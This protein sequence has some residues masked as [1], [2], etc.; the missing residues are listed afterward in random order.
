L[1]HVSCFMKF[2]RLLLTEIMSGIRMNCLRLLTQDVH[3]CA[4]DVLAL[5]G[6]QSM[7]E[8]GC[9]VLVGVLIP[10]TQGTNE[11]SK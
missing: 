1:L 11:W 3:P 5:L 10:A 7:Q 2:K 9:I 4:E 8:V 6:V